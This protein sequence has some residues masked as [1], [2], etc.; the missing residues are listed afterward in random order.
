[1]KLYEKLLGHLFKYAKLTEVVRQNNNL[2]IDLLNKVRDGNIDDDVENF[3]RQD[4]YENLMKIIQKM[5]CTYNFRKWT[6]QNRLRL[7]EI[8]FKKINITR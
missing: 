8:D 6:F 5:P 2:F 3:S 7:A 1:M 4:L